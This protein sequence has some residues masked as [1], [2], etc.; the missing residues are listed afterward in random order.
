[1]YVAVG[2][3][4]DSVSLVLVNQDTGMCI[5]AHLRLLLLGLMSSSALLGENVVL[6]VRNAHESCDVHTTS[7]HQ[8]VHFT[9]QQSVKTVF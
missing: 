7:V 4:P 9:Q 8:R 2:S 1:M 3:E 6:D 5:L